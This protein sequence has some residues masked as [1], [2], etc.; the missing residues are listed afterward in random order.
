MPWKELYKI[1]KI[2]RNFF[3]FISKS[4]S[5]R[6]RKSKS[7]LTRKCSANVQWKGNQFGTFSMTYLVY[8]MGKYLKRLW[9]ISFWKCRWI[10]LRHNRCNQQKI[11]SMHSLNKKNTTRLIHWKYQYLLNQEH[12]NILLMNSVLL[13][14]MH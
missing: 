14:L 13:T 5:S 4:W 9:W 7:K 12:N 3:S 8:L 10:Q 6:S 1:K 2:K 11:L